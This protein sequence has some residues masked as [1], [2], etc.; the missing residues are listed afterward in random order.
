MECIR[1]EIEKMNL[2]RENINALA[3]IDSRIDESTR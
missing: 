2:I 3:K 1:L